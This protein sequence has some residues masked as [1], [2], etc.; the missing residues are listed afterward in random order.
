MEG[1]LVEWQNWQNKPLHSKLGL[2][3]LNGSDL[4]GLE[5]FWPR[6]DIRVFADGAANHIF[7]N[8]CKNEHLLIP[9]FICGDLDSIR[10]D[11]ASFFCDCGTELRKQD[12]QNTND[13]EKCIFEMQKRAIESAFHDEV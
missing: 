9:D 10:S 13:M 4:T 5:W 8:F 3:V 12:D 6:A 7:D 1:V 11:V 2:L